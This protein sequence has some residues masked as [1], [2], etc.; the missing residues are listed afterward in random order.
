QV[1]QE[2]DPADGAEL[3][4]RGQLFLDGDGVDGPR[5]GLERLHGREDLA[6]ARVVEVLGREGVDV[7]QG[8]VAQQDA[9]EDRGLG[10]EVVRRDAA[11]H[12]PRPYTEH[13]WRSL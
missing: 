12:R 2:R 10:I 4:G 6:V 8:L 11:L 1:R 5:L 7:V 13:L 3:A 9:A